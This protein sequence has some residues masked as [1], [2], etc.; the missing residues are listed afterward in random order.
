M[1]TLEP[2]PRPCWSA[3]GEGGVALLSL[4]Q[5]FLLAACWTKE[6]VTRVTAKKQD[7]SRQQLSH[8]RVAFR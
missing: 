5:C 2:C 6:L 3:S 1:R 4:I 8:D 7:G